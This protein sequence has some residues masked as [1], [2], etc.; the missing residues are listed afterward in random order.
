MKQ[1]MNEE[2]KDL[3]AANKLFQFELER[4]QNLFR[5]L[6]QELQITMEEKKA[7][8]NALM[9]NAREATIAEKKNRRAGSVSISNVHDKLSLQTLLP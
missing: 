5:V 6:H 3:R 7:Q 4:N 1:L 8:N 9:E 2:V